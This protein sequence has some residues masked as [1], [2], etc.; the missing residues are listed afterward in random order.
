MRSYLERFDDW[1]DV[2][3]DVAHRRATFFLAAALIGSIVALLTLILP[4][5]HDLER[6]FLPAARAMVAGGSPYDAMSFYNPPWALLPTLPL[7]LLPAEGARALWFSIGVLVYV[8]V[9]R[10]YEA[11]PWALAGVM[12]SAP[13]LYTLFMGN[14]DWLCLLGLLLPPEWGLPLLIIKPQVGGGVALLWLW[15]AYRENRLIETLLPVCVLLFLSF[16]LYGPWYL[17][18][19]D[20]PS[21]SWR[22]NIAGGWFSH[23]V[24]GLILFVA[25]RRDEDRIALVGA[26]LLSPY[27]A[28]GSIGGAFIAAAKWPFWT[29]VCN[30]LLWV[31]L[32][33]NRSPT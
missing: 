19:V 10:K 16:A 8:A 27:L 5:A 4:T 14:N 21:R 6:I 20:L 17:S 9:L 31:I 3:R 30:V 24:G 18:W 1:L 28:G 12:L 13:V 32:L 25:L 11:E 22:W 7:L 2:P 29:T 23:L 26:P 15:R 33:T